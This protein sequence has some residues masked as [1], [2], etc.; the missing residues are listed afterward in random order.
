MTTA[1]GAAERWLLSCEHG[2]REVPVDY[3]AL[4]EGAEPVLNSHR[5]WDA[6]AL[7]VFEILRTGADAAYPVH[8]TR[9]LIDLNRSLHHPQVFSEFTR[10]LGAEA[11]RDIIA[12]WWQPW[13]SAVAGKISAWLES[14]AHVRHLSVH[15]FTPELDGKCRNADIGLLYDPSRLTERQICRAWRRRLELRGF[16][17]RLNYPYRGTADGHTTALRRRFGAAYSGIE[18]ELNQSLLPASRETLCDDLLQTAPWKP[19]ILDRPQPE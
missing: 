6:G 12:R 16:R 10:A 3:A 13:R 9:L 8:T 15:S 4:F 11:H 7:D 14:G 2:G 5:G 19:G 17:V 1:G 18:L